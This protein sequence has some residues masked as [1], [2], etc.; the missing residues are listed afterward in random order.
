MILDWD[1][2]RI[3]KKEYFFLTLDASGIPLPIFKKTDDID[4]S[5]IE[6]F[7]MINKKSTKNK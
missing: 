5:Y 7:N 2:F 6:V 3:L 4:K 1:D